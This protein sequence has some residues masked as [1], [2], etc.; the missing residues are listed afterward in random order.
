M[1]KETQKSKPRMKFALA[2]RLCVALLGIGVGMTLLWSEQWS[3][4]AIWLPITLIVV[5]GLALGLF[6]RL[7]GNN[8]KQESKNSRDTDTENNDDKFEL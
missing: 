8:K 3:G 1:E 6:L 2:V 5:S 4:N 7:T